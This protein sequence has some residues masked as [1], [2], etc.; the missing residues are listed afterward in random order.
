MRLRAILPLFVLAALLSI[1]MHV[2]VSFARNPDL[3]E[4][5]R[6]IERKG[7]RWRAQ[8]TSISRL[9]AEERRKR[10]GSYVPFATDKE[11]APAPAPG[12]LPAALDWRDYNGASYVTTVKE[13]ASCGACWS[14]APTAALESNILISRNTPGVELDLSEQTL[15]SCNGMGT[16]YGGWIDLASDFIRDIGLPDETCCSYAG[17]EGFCSSVCTDWP[18]KSYKIQDWYKVR[19]TAEAIKYALYNHG[20]LLTLLAVHTDFYYYREGV[21]SQSWGSFEG[22]HAAVIVGYDDAEQYFIVKS[23]WGTDWG[24]EGYSRIAYGEMASETQFG[25]WTVAYESPIPAD[26]PTLGDIPRRA[27]QQNA[28]KEAKEKKDSAPLSGLTG[29]ITDSAGN[30]VSGVSIKVGKYR[31]TTDSTGRYFIT[32]IPAGDYTIAVMKSGYVIS[33]E[34]ISIAPKTTATRN[35]AMTSSTASRLNEPGKEKK[36]ENRP[37]DQKEPDKLAANQAGILGPGWHATKAERITSA[38]AE[39]YYAAKRGELRS[40]RGG[41]APMAAA[42]ADISPEIQELARG[43]RHD[44]KL[45]YDY[46][47]N[48]IDYVPYFGSLKGATLTYLDGS[49]NDFD[50]ASLMIALLRASGYTGQYV[51]GTMTILGTTLSNWL[52]VNQ[53]AQAIGTVLASG[54]IPIDALWSDGG[55]QFRRVWVKA[56]IDGVD[57]VFDPAFKS[58]TYTDK[59]DLGQ[60]MSYSRNGLMAAVNSGATVTADYA[61]NMNEAN[62]RSML[63]TYASN[64]VNTIRTNYPNKNVDDIIG[65][66]KIVQTNLIGYQTSLPGT[67]TA[68]WSDIPSEYTTTLRIQHAGIDY[69]FNT[70]DLAGKRLTLTHAAGAGNRPEIRLDGALVVFGNATTIGSINNLTITIDHPYAANNGTYCDQTVIYT[71]ESGRNYAIVYNFGGISDALIRKRQQ[72]LETY[73]LQGL[74]DTTEA[75]LGETLNVMGQTWLAEYLV[76]G[77]LTCQLAETT[78][79][80]HHSVGLVAQEA[81]YYIDVKALFVSFCS[82]HGIDIDEIQG[83]KVTALVGSAFEHGI[84]EQLMGS[85]KPAVSTMKLF[86]I[87]NSTGRKMYHVTQANSA[88]ILGVNANCSDTI[89]Q[90]RSTYSCSDI[91][92]FRYAVGNNHTLILPENGQIV[93]NS[94][95][96]EG[97]IDKFFS[98]SKW[99]MGM[100]IGGSYFGGYGGYDIPVD[101][102]TVSE[103]TAVTTFD[104]TSSTIFQILSL[105]PPVPFGEP[106]DSASGAFLYDRTDLA[107][108]GGVPRGLAFSRSYNSNRN[109]SKRSLGYG[110]THN[111]DIYLSPASHGRPGL[112]GRQPVDAAGVIAA[113]YASLDLLKNSDAIDAWMAASLASKWAVDQVIDNAVTVYLGSKLMEY[114]KLADGTYASPPGITTQ[115]IR[116]GDG[117]YSLQERFGTRMNFNADKRL[118]Q[119]IDIDGNAVTFNYSGGQLAS[120]QDG[121]NHALTISYSGEKIASVSDSGGRSVSYA[122]NGDDLTGTPMRRARRGPI[123]TTAPVTG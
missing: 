66:R 61:Q 6:S 5:H 99:S 112:G 89:E 39:A 98:E 65:G 94:W 58:Y 71:P 114:I 103:N 118:S 10:L 87:A 46:V 84:L 19:P 48:H 81:G 62:L 11:R 25:L 20:P 2:S 64:L 36:P 38:E 17:E 53:I 122:Y 45:I 52:G 101:I 28:E 30:P 74:S 31:A 7:A 59:I 44:P 67:I 9:R 85:D 35:F 21:Y 40:A 34:S 69:T 32:S 80:I 41:R 93:L 23:S 3:D 43:L 123:S 79:T 82:R 57:Y 22:Y 113:L 33:I 15:L 111:Y 12:I 108:G 56:T 120:V 86:Q 42:A 109:L 4:I 105:T 29:V 97:Y 49:G 104:P 100:I 92:G 117:T 76:T 116:N 115:L 102:P 110:W 119:I 16:C 13:Q 70:A 8:D 78:L 27:A 72:Q 75:V 73:R 18:D 96:G 107:L 54:G 37:T 60:V 121:F 77:R 1:P 106:V 88:S 14:F 83:F 63:S 26:F 95:R 51:F 55:A 50:Q 90:I 47:H 24:E 68:Q 91:T